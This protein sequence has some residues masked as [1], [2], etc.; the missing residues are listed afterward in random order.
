MVWTFARGPHRLEIRREETSDGPS[1]VVAGGDA[2]GSTTFANIAA[3]LHQQSKLEAA[4]LDAGWSLTGF[5]P[6]RRSHAER[7]AA[8][9]DTFDR[10]RWW[11]DPAFRKRQT[12]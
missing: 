8:K 1:L 9:R 3:L 4:L 6:E 5:A 2:P 10:R 11:T 7:R 12:D